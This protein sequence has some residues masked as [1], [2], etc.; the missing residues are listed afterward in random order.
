M[1]ESFQNWSNE[2]HCGKHILS[3]SFTLYIFNFCEVVECK[4]MTDDNMLSHF[5]PFQILFIL[6]FVTIKLSLKPFPDISLSNDSLNCRLFSQNL[7][8]RVLINSSDMKKEFLMWFRT[9]STTNTITLQGLKTATDKAKP[10][11]G[12]KIFHWFMLPCFKFQH[13]FK[14]GIDPRLNFS[15]FKLQTQKQLIK[16]VFDLAPK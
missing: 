6:C 8:E 11:F 2:T 9:W 12:N 14:F 7:C 13:F 10:Y 1:I 4:N 5:S 3:Q 15:H 16:F